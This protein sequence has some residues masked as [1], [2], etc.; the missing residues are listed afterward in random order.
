MTNQLREHRI[1]ILAAD[2]EFSKASAAGD[3]E[4]PAWRISSTWRSTGGSP[5]GRVFRTGAARRSTA[6][7]GST[8]TPSPARTMP[9]A[10]LM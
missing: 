5:I 10:V 6:E 4:R 9:T 3:S 7:E 2:A 8:A 1:A